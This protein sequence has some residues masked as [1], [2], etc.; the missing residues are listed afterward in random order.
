MIVGC[1][2][3]WFLYRILHC[4]PKYTCARSVP[5]TSD[6]MQWWYDEICKAHI[7]MCEQYGWT[8]K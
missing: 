2:K 6:Q 5:L 4:K 7:E 8:P 1:L 3:C